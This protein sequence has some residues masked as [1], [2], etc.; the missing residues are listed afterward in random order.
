MFRVTPIRFELS[1]ETRRDGFDMT[2]EYNSDASRI[3]LRTRSLANGDA[4]Q[5]P[6]PGRA[7]K[8]RGRPSWRS[9]RSL[10]TLSP[11]S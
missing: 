1:P 3:V 7:G 6:A 9:R 11:E 8:T 5:Q 4:S 2:D 10:G